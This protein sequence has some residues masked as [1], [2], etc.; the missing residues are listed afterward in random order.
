[1]DGKGNLFLD[2]FDVYGE[3]PDDRVDVTPKH[4]ELSDGAHKPPFS[5]RRAPDRAPA[6]CG[7]STHQT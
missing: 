5:M 1:M 4:R 6:T 2:F 7:L 3:R